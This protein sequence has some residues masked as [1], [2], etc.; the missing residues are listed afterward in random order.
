MTANA[1][2]VTFQG[3]GNFELNGNTVSDVSLNQGMAFNNSTNL[4][5]L[6]FGGFADFDLTVGE[7]LHFWFTDNSNNLVNLF[8]K[9]SQVNTK[10]VPLSGLTFSFFGLESNSG[11]IFEASLSRTINEQGIVTSNSINLSGQVAAVPTPGA[12]LLFIS[13]LPLL[14]IS[15]KKGLQTNL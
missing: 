1:A 15:K 5:F 7:N 6:G 13:G 3:T 10:D 11:Q 4:S 8:G 14:F 9:I 12:L 2:T